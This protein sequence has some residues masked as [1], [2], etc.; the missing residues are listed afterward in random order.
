MT[1][2]KAGKIR[3]QSLVWGSDIVMSDD[4]ENANLPSRVTCVFLSARRTLALVDYQALISLLSSNLDVWIL[5]VSRPAFSLQRGE[6]KGYHSNY[7]LDIKSQF[8]IGP[9]K[10]SSDNPER[11]RTTIF[12]TRMTN[13]GKVVLR[14]GNYICKHV[15]EEKQKLVRE[16]EV[17]L[18]GRSL[19]WHPFS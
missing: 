19:L 17:L 4:I 9:V 10:M 8:T 11:I 16:I 5:V 18:E 3:T 13:Y 14:I 7:V 2:L 15:S 1:T 6:D 12:Q